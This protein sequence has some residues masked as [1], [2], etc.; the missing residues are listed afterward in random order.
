MTAS[1]KRA[2]L[3]SQLERGP[4]KTR[5]RTFGQNR[6]WDDSTKSVL[7]GRGID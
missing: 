3:K 7:G 2:G 4:G 6:S 1:K 5:E